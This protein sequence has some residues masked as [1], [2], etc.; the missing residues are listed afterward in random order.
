MKS[1]SIRVAVFAAIVLASPALTFAGGQPNHV[2]M[3]TKAE[4]QDRTGMTRAIN[5]G[6][7][8]GLSLRRNVSRT[9]SK[10]AKR[11]ATGDSAFTK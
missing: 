8:T 9:S 4:M 1:G 3:L 10:P 6:K 11:P 5:Q 7:G 2:R